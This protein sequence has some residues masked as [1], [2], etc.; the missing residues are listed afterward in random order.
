M[1]IFNITGVSATLIMAAMISSCSDKGYW[2]EAPREPGYSFDCSQYTESLS[3]GAQEIKIT[4]NRSVNTSD[5]SVNVTFTPGSNCPSDITVESPVVFAAGSNTAEV[6]VKIA[7]A[8]PPYTYSGKLTFD[9]EASYAGISSCDLK[10]PVSYTWTSIGTGQFLDAWVMDNAT[11]M[12]D[13]EIL[14]ADGFERYRVLNPYKEYYE[15][16]GSASWDNW[17]ATTGPAY[18]EFWEVADGTLSFTAYNSGL[19]YQ[20]VAGQNIGVYPYSAFTSGVAGYDIWYSKGLAVL[21]PIYYVNGVGGW[22]QQQ[23]AIQ[24]YLPE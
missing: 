13:V 10:M 1:K 20:A 8:Q 17:I 11:S 14:K 12:Y 7:D 3:P 18:V 16:I 9:G 23:F 5:A 4:L 15:T 22:G 19:I 21:S 2:E 24:I 6:I